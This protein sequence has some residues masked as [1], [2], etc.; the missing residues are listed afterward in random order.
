MICSFSY[1]TTHAPNLYHLDPN[2]QLNQTL[3]LSFP[4]SLLQMVR[5]NSLHRE[6]MFPPVFL[7]D[8][9][10]VSKYQY[11]E[12]WCESWSHTLNHYLV[13]TYSTTTYDSWKSIN[14]MHKT[15]NARRIEGDLFWTK[16]KFHY[17]VKPIEYMRN[18]YKSQYL[19]DN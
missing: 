5:V 19:F 8:F 6:G 13:S 18:G 10:F 4:R 3:S 1:V 15:A 17:L 12:C 11:F 9:C 14:Y 2:I 7:L 16:G